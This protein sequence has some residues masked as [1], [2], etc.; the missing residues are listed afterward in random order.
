MECS[1]WKSRAVSN[2]GSYRATIFLPDKIR[3]L[4]FSCSLLLDPEWCWLLTYP[5]F[6]VIDFKPGSLCG[7]RCK[8]HRRP[9]KHQPRFAP[10]DTRRSSHTFRDGAGVDQTHCGG[11]SLESWG[12]RSS[13]RWDELPCLTGS[14][15]VQ[16]CEEAVPEREGRNFPS[17][18]LMIGR[19][20]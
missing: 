19:V 6:V 2:S 11:A 13:T 5:K 10:A 4:Q 8:S 1:G 3:F 20:Q 12:S 17:L 16:T 9:G 15:A 7:G 18:H 14:L